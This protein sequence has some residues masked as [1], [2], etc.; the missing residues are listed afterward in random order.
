M[1]FSDP[2]THAVDLTAGVG[3]LGDSKDRRT[4]H[5]RWRDPQEVGHG[6]GRDE[7]RR[8]PRAGDSRVRLVGQP[9][10]SPRLLQVAEQHLSYGIG[11]RGDHNPEGSKKGQVH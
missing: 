2:A 4:A 9:D 11:I 8:R 3:V 5:G 7:E 10:Q 1:L 6:I